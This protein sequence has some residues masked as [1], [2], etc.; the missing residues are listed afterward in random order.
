MILL[1]LLLTIS[2]G[3]GA[4]AVSQV[5]DWSYQELNRYNSIYKGQLEKRCRKQIEKDLDWLTLLYD[6]GV[7][8]EKQFNDQADRLIDELVE[9]L[10]NSPNSQQDKVLK[11]ILKSIS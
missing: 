1:L 8:S 11:N 4:F 5:L 7:V 10:H 6:E 2:V 3:I 9:N